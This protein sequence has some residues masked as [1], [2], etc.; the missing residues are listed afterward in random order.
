MTFLDRR[1]KPSPA[2]DR[3]ATRPRIV[4]RHPFCGGTPQ[5][6]GNA[7]TI[8]RASG[9]AW[10]SAPARSSTSTATNLAT[11][12][13]NPTTPSGR[14]SRAQRRLT[15]AAR[16]G[17]SGFAGPS[18][19]IQGRFWRGNEFRVI[20]VGRN[21]KWPTL[22]AGAAGCGEKGG[23]PSLSLRRSGQC[24]GAHVI[25]CGCP[26]CRRY[27]AARDGL[28]C[29]LSCAKPSRSLRP[30]IRAGCSAFVGP[31]GSAGLACPLS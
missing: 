20:A 24:S 18:L 19:S 27:A 26:R 22:E 13:R 17:R 5:R 3:P 14:E 10:F 1:G 8:S 7:T 15:D 9:L 11:A 2:C 21:S 4:L 6:P 25:V 23:A 29:T 31:M 30:Q 16:S 12:P 28:R